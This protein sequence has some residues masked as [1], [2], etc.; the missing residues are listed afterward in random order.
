MLLRRPLSLAA[1]I[2]VAVVLVIGL[3]ARVAMLGGHDHGALIGGPFTLVDGDG[4]TVTDANFRGRYMLVYF[5]YTFC[6]D[7]CPTT[8]AEEAAALDKLPPAEAARIQP[9]FITVDPE[10]DTPKVVKSYA[11][12]FYPRMIGLTGSVAQISAVERAYKVYAAK[13]SDGKGGYSMD[14]SSIIYLMGPDGRF[15]AHF[16]HGVSVDQMAAQLH[17]YVSGS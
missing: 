6:P 16:A 5:G 9:L 10:R 3:V 7:V 4:K 12:A 17:K 1:L 14:H 8:L 15:L 11:A 13:A 2:A